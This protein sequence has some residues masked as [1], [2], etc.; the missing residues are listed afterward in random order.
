MP[1][2][3]RPELILDYMASNLP[4]RS[5]EFTIGST[6]EKDVEPGKSSEQY[7]QDRA[8]TGQAEMRGEDW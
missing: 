5:T 7:A 3:G 6:T 2:A 1:K 8:F 4:S